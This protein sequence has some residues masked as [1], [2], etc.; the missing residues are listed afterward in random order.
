MLSAQRLA[1]VRRR[2]ILN[3]TYALHKKRQKTNPW[4]CAVTYSLSL[5]HL[6]TEKLLRIGEYSIQMA[7]SDRPTSH[8]KDA[9]KARRGSSTALAVT[10][11]RDSQKLIDVAAAPAAASFSRVVQ[12]LS[13]YSP[14]TSDVAH[15]GGLED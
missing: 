5:M 8:W 13:K 1:Y 10:F 14:T 6:H 7:I 15:F 2:N 11:A 3:I 12:Y 9:E 4:H